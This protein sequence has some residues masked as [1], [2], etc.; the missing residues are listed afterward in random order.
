MREIKFRA[1]DG[2]RML[3]EKF[4]FDHAHYAD[5]SN[6]WHWMQYTGLKDKNGVEIYEGDVVECIHTE[7]LSW[8]KTYS[9]IGVVEFT[10]R[11]AFAVKCLKKGSENAKDISKSYFFLSFHPDK[12][13]HVKSNIYQNPQ[14]LK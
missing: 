12:E 2:K 9:D 10:D 11:G 13:F 1:W 5:F 7:G 6:S 4:L 3:S 8:Q 14:L